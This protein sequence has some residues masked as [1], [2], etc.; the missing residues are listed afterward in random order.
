[1]RN[2]AA[3]L[4]RPAAALAAGA[5][6]V[7]ALAPYGFSLIQIISLAFFFHLLLGATTIRQGFFT[8]W[9]YGTGWM[10]AGVH[11]LYFSMHRYGG[12]NPWLAAAA[13]ILLGLFMG[14]LPAAAA[15]LASIVRLRLAA[16]DTIAALFILPSA[17]TLA[18]WTRGWLFTG[19]PWAVPG[20]AHTD[21]ALTGF[22]PVFGLYGITLLAAF[23]SGCA[24]LLVNRRLPHRNLLFFA[25]AA[26]IL[27]GYALRFVSW[28]TPAGEPVSI[29][30]LQGNIPQEMKFSPDA[31]A[32]TLEQYAGMITAAPADLIV[33]PETAIPQY[34]HTIPIEWYRKLETFAIKNGAALAVGIPVAD[35]LRQ[36]T[37]SLVV[38]SP[39]STHP[40]HLAYRYNKQHLVPF[41]EFIPPGFRWF[42]NLL[43]IPMGDF[44]RGQE[45][46]PPFAVNSQWVLPN[47]CYEDIFGEE[48]ARQIR[49]AR[50]AGVPEPGILLNLSNIA[51][52][53]DSLALPQHLQISRMR[54]LET[55]RPM[56]RATNT[57]MTAVI[58]AN[59]Q[60]LGELPPWEK[61]SL[62]TTIQGRNGATPYIR[63]GNHPAILAC[64]ILLL[65]GAVF[66]HWRQT[67]QPG[68]RPHPLAGKNDLGEL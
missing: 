25:G 31:L 38:I 29:R 3:A 21:N 51:W 15:A 56:L 2:A 60:I 57:G 22:A 47:I 33:T 11:W 45:I 23:L 43:H 67:R 26:V 42:T 19:F 18:E 39:E 52:F 62:Q 58:D 13:V 37:N 6:L 34:L 30:L 1:M 12:L 5:L 32:N 61:A 10:I 54:A 14:L 63:F 65:G 17:L 50:Q 59:G 49:A 48:I 53:G 27:C 16:S 66:S 9:A 68:Y 20:Y 64:L 40:Y 35:S 41:G 36:F 4:K 8:G 55:R 7:F 46:Q 24:L 44:T 28:T